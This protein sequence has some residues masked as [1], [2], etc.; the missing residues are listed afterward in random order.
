[1]N[2]KYLKTVTA[3]FMNYHYL[4]GLPLNQK[5]QLNIYQFQHAVVK[6]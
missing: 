4:L 2:L 6:V 5:L 1:M 3:K